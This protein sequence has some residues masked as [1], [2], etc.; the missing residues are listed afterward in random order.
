[1]DP[2]TLLTFGA[3]GRI[4]LMFVRRKKDDVE[5]IRNAH[6]ELSDAEVDLAAS[7]K[8]A[9]FYGYAKLCEKPGEQVETPAPP[10]GF[11]GWC[12]SIG[13]IVFGTLGVLIAAAVVLLIP[14]VILWKLS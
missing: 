13:I 2:V 11:L 1:M 9:E 12:A 7:K 6:P 8:R 4:I 14:F 10:R 5:K 3:V